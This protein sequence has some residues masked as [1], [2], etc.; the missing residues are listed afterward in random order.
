MCPNS[1]REI[2]KLNSELKPCFFQEWY[3]HMLTLM[4]LWDWPTTNK[5]L[6]MENMSSLAHQR[7]WRFEVNFTQKTKVTGLSSNAPINFVQCR[8]HIQITAWCDERNENDYNFIHVHT[9]ITAVIVI[10]ETKSIHL[11][12]IYWKSTVLPVYHCD[13]GTWGL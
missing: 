5:N 11:T 8:R 1:H 7:D 4:K 9:L 3:Y 10:F 2:A 13:G 12:N 6:N